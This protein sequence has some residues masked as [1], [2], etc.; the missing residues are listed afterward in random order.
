MDYKKLGLI[1]KNARICANLKQSDAASVVGVTFQNISSWE[2]GKSKIDI[3]T[4][5][6]LCDLYGL[7]F[8]R[9]L[10]EAD[11]KKVPEVSPRGKYDDIIKLLDLLC[12]DQLAEARGYIKR[13]VDE[14][15][16]AGAAKQISARD[17]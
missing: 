2:L 17:A 5:S 4:F 3:D 11:N 7:D 12:T 8:V 6:K 9:A 16:A 14:N 15:E 13:M 10:Q 1:L